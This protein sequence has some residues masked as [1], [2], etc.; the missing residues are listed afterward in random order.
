VQQGDAL[1]ID[2]LDRS[3]VEHLACRRR[4]TAGGD[5]NADAARWWWGF[6]AA[7]AEAES[8][9]TGTSLAGTRLSTTRQWPAPASHAGKNRRMH[10]GMNRAMP[11]VWVHKVGEEPRHEGR[12]LALAVNH[13]P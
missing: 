3:R 2:R 1:N 4:S 11:P 5:A 13:T 12:L 10:V 6:H 9:P 7:S 8:W